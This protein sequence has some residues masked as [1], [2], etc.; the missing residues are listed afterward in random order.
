MAFT[1]LVPTENAKRLIITQRRLTALAWLMVDF[2]DLEL[3]KSWTQGKAHAVL[4]AL[5]IYEGSRDQDL[6]S[7]DPNTLRSQARSNGLR[8]NRGAAG[9]ML[10]LL[11]KAHAFVGFIEGT[12]RYAPHFEG[13]SWKLLT[14]GAMTARGKTVGDPDYGSFVID[15]VTATAVDPSQRM[16]NHNGVQYPITRRGFARGSGIHQLWLDAEQGSGFN[17]IT[18]LGTALKRFPRTLQSPRLLPAFVA[19]PT[20]FHIGA[21]EIRN[22]EGRNARE[23][24][25]QVDYSLFFTKDNVGNFV[26]AEV[27]SSPAA[28]AASSSTLTMD[29]VERLIY[30][31][32]WGKIGTPDRRSLLFTFAIANMIHDV[33]GANSPAGQLRQ[34][35]LYLLNQ[36]L[37]SGECALV[38]WLYN[39]I[40]LANA[41]AYGANRERIKVKEE[42]RKF[43][44]ILKS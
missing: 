3:G 43:Y 6:Q 33:P 24:L 4:D 8:M 26:A 18:L 13:G 20:R 32:T 5:D 14:T 39:A 16:G 28:P 22:C 40:N 15:P 27:G 12:D 31:C 1:R 38:P 42:L 21:N 23:W 44:D 41:Q 36:I 37:P 7:V 17:V 10:D 29:Q 35:V 11:K 2:A 9:R 34:D 19:N 30:I 25:R